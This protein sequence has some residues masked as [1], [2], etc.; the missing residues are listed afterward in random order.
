MF[1][2]RGQFV[3]CINV[4]YLHLSAV[5]ASTLLAKTF[6]LTEFLFLVRVCVR[7]CTQVGCVCVCVCMCVCVVTEAQG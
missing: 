7:A 2:S 4:F 1:D 5:K 6:S 3:K